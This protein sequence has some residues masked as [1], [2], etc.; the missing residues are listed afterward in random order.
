M[1][2]FKPDPHLD[3][4]VAKTRIVLFNNEVIEAWVHY[5]KDQR[6]Q[7]MLNDQRHFI[8]VHVLRTGG[9]PTYQVMFVQKS[10]I[11]TIEF[12]DYES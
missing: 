6:V 1:D 5:S 9:A 8:P 4:K 11:L 10:Q 2:E 7:D 12:F 3:T